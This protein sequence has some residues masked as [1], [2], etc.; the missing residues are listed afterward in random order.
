MSALPKLKTLH[1]QH[2]TTPGGECLV[3]LPVAEWETI[4]T[5]IEDLEDIE[6]AQTVLSQIAT[7][8]EHV[9]AWEEIKAEHDL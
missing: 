2:L 7:G 3:I 8:D 4:L 6:D 1:P 5:L 9:V